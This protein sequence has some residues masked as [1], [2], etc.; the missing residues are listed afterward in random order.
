MAAQHLLPDLVRPSS[1]QQQ[2]NQTTRKMQKLA[3]LGGS[4][5][6]ASLTGKK[7]MNQS[8]NMELK[9]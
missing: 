8:E 2:L 7:S 5:Q 9:M 1:G 3:L 6:A 4:T